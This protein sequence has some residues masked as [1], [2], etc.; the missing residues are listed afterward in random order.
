MGEKQK[1][2]LAYSGGLDTSCI[3]VWLQEQGYEVLCFAADVGQV[4]DWDEVKK[5]ALQLGAKKMFVE[6][7]KKEF[8]SEFIFPAIQWNAIYEN[9]YLMGTSLARPCIARAQIRIAKQEG[10]QYVSHG[11]TGKG[12]DQVRFELCFYALDKNIK[13]IAPWRDPKFFNRF[14]G[15]ADLLKYA[16]EKKIPVDQTPKK[17]YSID[18]NIH[19]LSYES[20]ILEDPSIAPPNDIWKRTVDPEQAPDKPE[21]IKVHFV[22]GCP[23]KVEHGDKSFTDP[24]ELFAYVNDL[25]SKHGIGRIDIVENRFVGIKSRGIYEAPGA[26]ILRLAHIDIEGIAMDREVHLLRD[27]L[28]PKFSEYAYNGFWYSPEMDFLNSAL[29]KSQEAISGWVELKLYKGNCYVLS[30]ASPSSLYNQDLSSMDVEG[31]FNPT[32]STSCYYVTI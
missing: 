13:V 6:D 25:G 16:E 27:L 1:V 22:D 4:E 17:S 2:L 20:G 9:R 30:R 18:E 5:K 7:L 26:T 31:G 14:E 28:Q 21:I 24:L 29:K 15:R 19:H 3:L 11:A 10:C 23:S 32:Q 12:N 8:V